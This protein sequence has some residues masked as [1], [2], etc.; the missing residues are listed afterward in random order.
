[1]KTN[2]KTNNNTISARLQSIVSRYNNNDK[3]AQGELYRLLLEIGKKQYEI[4]WS[5][6][7]ITPEDAEDLIAEKA[8]DLVISNRLKGQVGVKSY[9]DNTFKYAFYDF[10]RSLKSKNTVSI[11]LG[12]AEDDTYCIHEPGECTND[13][14]SKLEYEDLKRAINEGIQSLPHKPRTVLN[15]ALK[16]GLDSDEIMEELKLSRNNV[17]H[18]H[19]RGINK[20]KQ[21]LPDGGY[22][23]HD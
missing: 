19:F 13:G 22:G 8:S 10:L 4:K 17:N 3:K 23:R 16:K 18:A 5:L 6:S 20:L 14:E 21:Y 9:V 11:E 7:R 12:N 1:M 15:L 2:T